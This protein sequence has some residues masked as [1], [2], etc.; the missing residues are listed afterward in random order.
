MRDRLQTLW[1]RCFLILSLLG[2]A[3]CSSDETF[4]RPSLFDAGSDGVDHD[5]AEVDI[6]LTDTSVS[7]DVGMDDVEFEDTD[8][9]DI[10][11]ADSG[12]DADTAVAD[13]GPEDT[14][15][16]DAGRPDTGPE[17]TGP[18][19]TGPEDVGPEDAGP[20]ITIPTWT[21]KSLAKMTAPRQSFSLATHGGRLYVTGGMGLDN[22]PSDVLL[23]YN[24]D[25]DEWFGS[26][27][28]PL[29]RH[30]PGSAVALGQIY[31]VGGTGGGGAPLDAMVR[32]NPGQAL[33]KVL[34]ANPSPG[35]CMAGIGIQ[36]RI[37]M[38]GGRNGSA[39]VQSFN[40][41]QG[42]WF[43]HE[44]MPTG[45]SRHAAVS[46]G[47]SVVLIGGASHDSPIGKTVYSSVDVY[48]TLADTWT[49]GPPAPFARYDMAAAV[50]QGQI[51]VFGGANEA[52]LPSDEI[53]VL[54][55]NKGWVKAGTMS[56]AR[57]GH[58]VAVNSAGM[59][60]VGG[61]PGDGLPFDSLELMEFE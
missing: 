23:I 38:F 52:G 9:G 10:G 45:R 29:A 17:D 59:Y 20:T 46:L 55:L 47:T 18:E 28:V 51:F 27:Q 54:E 15:P 12:P 14:G 7:D 32:F 24:N 57:R 16:D 13:T 25:L 31:V 2:L 11:S 49:A 39:L 37:W 34:F 6:G 4:S 53:W 35:C 61:A 41:A 50:R 22:Q 30:S 21:V 19:D 5:A 33:W 60:I 26:A 42:I 44:P 48:D 8:P 58:G 36:D 40:P 56:I 43:D 1:L 3:G